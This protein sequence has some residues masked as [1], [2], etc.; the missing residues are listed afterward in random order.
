MSKR[1]EKKLWK[2]ADREAQ[3][4]A[5]HESV[6]SRYGI[7]LRTPRIVSLGVARTTIVAGLGEGAGALGDGAGGMGKLIY[8]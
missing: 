1:M 2:E 3:A 6:A 5:Y 7:N 8:E 4:I